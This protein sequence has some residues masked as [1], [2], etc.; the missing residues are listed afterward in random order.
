MCGI[1][2]YFGQ[3]NQETLAKMT[4]TLSYR[5]PDDSGIFCDEKIGLGHTRL[6]II[7]LSSSGHQPMSNQAQ[8]IWLV[9]NGEIYNF[10]DLQKNLEKKG[11]KFKST[12]DTEVIIHLYEEYGENLFSKLNGMF[13]LAIYDQTKKKIILARDRL[14]KKPLYWTIQKNTL[15]FGSELKSLLA[16]PNFTK[17]LNLESLNQYLLYEYV[18]TPNTIFKNTYKLEPGTYLI[19][20][21]K[22]KNLKTFWDITFSDSNLNEKEALS[23]LDQ[24]LNQAVKSRLVS[25]VPLGIFL[26]GGIDS[27]AICYYAQKN[28]TQKI[29]T[30]SIGFSEKSFDESIY[31][32]QVAKH[33]GTEHSEKIFDARECINIIPEVF[34][35]LDEP[36][37]DSSILPTFL[38]SRFTREKVTV[39]L[40]GDGGDELFMGY[41]TFLAEQFARYYDLVPG[42]I[43]NA[44]TAGANILPTS[45]SN[46]SLDFKLKKFTAGFENNKNYRHHIWLGSFDKSARAKLFNANVWQSLKT[47]NEFTTLD[48]C[49]EKY[50][51]IDFKKQLILLYLKTYLMDD[52]LVKMDRASMFNSLEVRTPFLDYKLVDFANSL[53][54]KYKIRGTKRKYILN[55]LMEKKLPPEIIKRKKKG[56]GMPMAAWLAKDL[57]PLALDLLNE[58]SIKSQNLFEPAFITD[59]LK[60]HFEKKQDNRKTIWTLLVFQMWY[61]KWMK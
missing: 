45:F 2:G 54:N 47:K 8:T 19:F 31:A 13:A 59:L 38:L 37:A 9:F 56:F 26:S 58:D 18:P 41:D 43:K 1:A 49:L 34:D 11:Y 12:S 57:K 39:A 29:K 61:N 48:N 16:H 17:D 23:H 7:D 36:L 15:I 6:S 5:G 42:F 52:I 24:E 3:G 40:G 53:P 4:K 14:G 28:S 10:K 51:N 25:D 22:T 60:N 21:G 50:K 30:F 27:S 55:K 33:L 32:R 46:I 35:K 20:D 44:I